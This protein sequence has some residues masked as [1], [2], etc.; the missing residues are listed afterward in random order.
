MAAAASGGGGANTGSVYSEAETFHIVNSNLGDFDFLELRSLLLSFVKVNW[1]KA[2]WDNKTIITKIKDLIILLQI[3]T[4]ILTKIE[5]PVEI[6]GVVAKVKLEDYIERL[7]HHFLYEFEKPYVDELNKMIMT[8]GLVNL[9]AEEIDPIVGDLQ[10]ISSNLTLGVSAE[11]NS[12]SEPNSGSNNSGYNSSGGGRRR[13]GKKL[14]RGRRRAGRR[15]GRKVT[16]RL[17]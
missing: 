7:Q 17:R 14:T 16:R 10:K 9:I 3:L 1:K 12:N 8:D 4:N 5:P 15:S 11:S 6:D 2:P 13:K